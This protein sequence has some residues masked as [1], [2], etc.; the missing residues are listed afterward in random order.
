[1]NSIINSGINRGGI[2]VILELGAGYGRNAFVFSKALPKAKYIIVDIFPALYLSWKY[3][4][5]Q[6][7]DRK[8]FQFREFE[9]FLQVKQEFEDSDLLFLSPHQLKLLPEKSVD[10]F[11]NISSFQEMIKSQIDYYFQEVER[12]VKGYF[13]FKQ[14]KESKI[15]F[16]NILIKESDYPV[17]PEWTKIYSR[18]CEVQTRFF[19]ALYKL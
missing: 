19:E 10:L 15:P 1:Y 8:F 14:W 12:L 11:I 4:S 5:N 9:S 16:D 3:L 17:K 7:P 13:Y 6:F 18:E 2:N